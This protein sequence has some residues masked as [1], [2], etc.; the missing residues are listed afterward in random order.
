MNPSAQKTS[1]GATKRVVQ[2]SSGSKSWIWIGGLVVVLIAALV[3][4]AVTRGDK[5]G[6]TA[7]NDTSPTV[8]GGLPR[9][10]Q[11]TTDD[12][13]GKTLPTIS[14]ETLAG[15]PFTLSGTD[16]KA[17]IIAVVAHWCPHC[18]REVPL[19]ATH[20]ETTPMPDDVELVA[21]STAVAKER[22]N[23]PPKKW[24]DA[25]GWPTPVMA[26]S[27]DSTAA[28]TYGLTS[29]PYFVVVDAEGKVVFRTSGE[30]TTDQFDQM[31][32]AAQTGEAPA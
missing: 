18:Q 15:E 12:A 14:G 1:Q 21:V 4:I 13:I 25:A 29:F 28:K 8:E 7:V 2:P 6:E 23:W 16:G 10:V 27:A 20:L 17:K 26:D 19:I 24:L 30:I 9:F 32:K 31:V 3:A 11:G 5:K 22:G